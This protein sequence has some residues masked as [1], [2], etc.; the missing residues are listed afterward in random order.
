MPARM[1]LI[2]RYT[3]GVSEAY[4]K[5]TYYNA[6]LFSN[7]TIMEELAQSFDT[8]VIADWK[9]FMPDFVTFLDITVRSPSYPFPVVH[10]LADVGALDLEAQDVMPA[11]LPL[12]LKK[13][14]SGNLNG[15]TGA[16]Y[17][18]LRPVRFG[19][20]FLSWLP[21]TFNSSNGFV[22]PGGAAGTA[23][24]AFLASA[25]AD[26]SAGGGLW[27]PVVPGDVLPAAGSRPARTTP[28]MGQIASFLPVRFTKLD[29]RED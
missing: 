24:T 10:P 15:D 9:G 13:V 6:A 7:A 1:D 2:V 22:N 29:S 5:F 21:E 19:R 23:W 25:G 28:V 26:R 3:D 14:V 27:E 11:H 4:S 8:N 12:N 16:A 17:T 18:G 20:V